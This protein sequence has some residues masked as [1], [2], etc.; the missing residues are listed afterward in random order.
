MKEVNINGDE[1]NLVILDKLEISLAYPKN[2]KESKK[3]YIIENQKRLCNTIKDYRVILYRRRKRNGSFSKTKI[4]RREDFYKN[5]KL[6][7]EGN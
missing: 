2:E 3:C 1:I 7:K 6:I 4:M 5:F